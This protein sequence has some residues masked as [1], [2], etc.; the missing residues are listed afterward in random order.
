MTV[1]SSTLQDGD[2]HID[3]EGTV[4][5]SVSRFAQSATERPQTLN[6]YHQDQLLHS[7]PID[8]TVGDGFEFE[9]TVVIPD[10]LPEAY[11]IRAETTENIAGNKAF[12]ES[13]VSLTWEQDAAAFPTLSSPLSIAFAAAPTVSVV[14]QATL[15]LGNG[16]PQPGDSASVET[17]ADS[18][19][20]T[21]N[22]LIPATPT[23]L[24]APCRLEIEHPEGFSPTQIDSVFVKLELAAPGFPKNKIVGRWIE[25]GADTRIFRA[26]DRILGNAALKN[27]GTSQ[28]DLRGTP[29]SGIEASTVRFPSLPAELA[30]AGLQLVSGG[31]AYDLINKGGTWYPEDPDEAGEIKRFVPSAHPVPGRIQAPGYDAD[32]GVLNF[33]LRFPETSDVD[34][35]EIFILPGDESSGNP[36]PPQAAA[37]TYSLSTASST[38]P[39]PWQP[40]N[41]VIPEHIIWAY[42]FLNAS[43]KFAEE[44]LNGYL[45]GGHQIATGDFWNDMSTSVNWGTDLSTHEDNVRT[46]SIEEDVNPIHAARLLFEGLKE[47]Y[48][49]DEV[50]DD[51]EWED[52]MDEIAAFQAAAAIA[53][54]KTQQT[55]IAATELYL[56]GLGIINEGL[57]WIIVINDVA[58]GDYESLAGALPFVSPGLIK[59]GGFLK[60]RKVTGTVTDALDTGGVATLQ[61]LYRES[62]LRVM[63]V[64]MEEKN[65]SESLRKALSTSGG[66]IDPPTKKMHGDLR[67]AMEAIGPKPKWGKTA[68]KLCRDGKYRS[69]EIAEAHHDLAWKHRNWFAKHGLNV[70]NPAFG[71]WASKA[72][73]YIWHNEMSPNFN[74]VWDAYKLS[75]D[76]IV[77]NGGNP[78]TAAE[79]LQKLQEVRSIF[80]V[81]GATYNP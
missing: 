6:F 24:T 11:V 30:A 72:D 3:L 62:D 7:I 71:R 2:L 41:P 26:G 36:P 60:L 5:D 63:G 43:D 53:V 49:H 77:E 46:I 75:E 32:E 44:L 16:A 29:P 48:L 80:V 79:I 27:S 22:L 58:E 17:A 69:Y 34:A 59:A 66:P 15:F 8:A 42:R 19:T 65:F 4:T 51:F 1:V 39:P 20:F 57:D 76:E 81:T 13:S 78:F 37:R 64:M 70:N 47:M 50:A 68:P 61:Q 73:H 28:Q 52:P 54:Q 55:A 14:D 21:G 45:R 9:E 23:N 40:G 74:E 56:S 25:T 10:A 67:K 33:Q 18:M 35:T 38:T 12:D 31:I